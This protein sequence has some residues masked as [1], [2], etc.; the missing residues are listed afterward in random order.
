MNREK[1]IEHLSGHADAYL[2]EIG[3]HFG[4]SGTAIFK[5]CKRWKITRKKTLC[6]SARNEKKRKAFRRE[7]SVIDKKSLIYVDECGLELEC[8]RTHARAI[9]GE[10]IEAATESIHPQRISIISAY[11][12]K[13]LQAP[14][15]LEGTT[16]S[17]IFNAWIEH[18]LVPS[19]IPGQTVILDNARFHQSKRT[20]ELI[21]NAG[22]HLKFL[23]PYSPD[24]NPIEP[25]WLKL[26]SRLRKAKPSPSQTLQ[27]LDSL[28]VNMSKH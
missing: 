7:L 18:L 1:L 2:T 5:A 13:Q 15:H 14:M 27:T 16:D 26:K 17:D 11:N 22:C 8:H 21:Q 3:D 12:Q 25:C 10:K 20:E 6:C 24:L 28:I 19:L 9:R 4:V 23:P